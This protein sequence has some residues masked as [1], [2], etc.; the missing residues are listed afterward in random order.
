MEEK[1]KPHSPEHR[2]KIRQNMLRI[3]AERRKIKK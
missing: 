3:H 2:E 1:I